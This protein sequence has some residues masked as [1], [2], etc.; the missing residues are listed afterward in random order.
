MDKLLKEYLDARDLLF[1][2]EA[3]I[4]RLKVETDFTKAI[5]EV[6]QSA[7]TLAEARLA[8]S[9]DE[10]SL[11]SIEWKPPPDDDYWKFNEEPGRLGRVQ[12]VANNNGKRVFVRGP[13]GQLAH[14]ALPEQKEPERLLLTLY[15]HR[16]LKDSSF[17]V[18]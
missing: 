17:V 12:S 11:P 13:Q 6:A 14:A 2:T 4:E 18:L 10:A 3:E 7:L 15:Q 16:D 8:K 9:M 5:L 1:R